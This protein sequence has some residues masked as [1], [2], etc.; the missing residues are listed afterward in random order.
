MSRESSA[1]RAYL[2][3][4]ERKLWL[5][6]PRPPPTSI[7]STTRQGRERRNPR[8]CRRTAL[9]DTMKE[10][11]PKLSYEFYIAAPPE[12]VWNALTDGEQT[13]QYF[14]GCRVESTFEKGAPI[15][16]VADGSFK[17]LEG[18]VLEITPGKK[19]STTYRPLWD[20]AVSKDAPSRVTWGLAAS[21]DVT[22]LTL[23][24][25]AFKGGKSSYEQSASGW[26]LILSSLKSYVETGKALKMG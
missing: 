6:I 11:D 19:L 15:A 13:K 3:E 8:C 10:D 21:G 14:Y 4:R 12:K 18:D 25:D 5:R 1:I 24:H 17:M 20:A 2:G 23:I 9:E 7:E 26:P 16:Y 22:K